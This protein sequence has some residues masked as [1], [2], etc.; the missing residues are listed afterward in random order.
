MT[1]GASVNTKAL[2]KFSGK[3]RQQYG[4]AL[5]AWVGVIKKCFFFLKCGCGALTAL[6]KWGKLCFD[7]V[8]VTGGLPWDVLALPWREA[9]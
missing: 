1:D 6:R 7:R 4:V 8:W 3:R 9:F 2:C 5:R